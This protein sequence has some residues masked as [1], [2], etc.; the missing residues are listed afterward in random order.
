MLSSA[1]QPY[2]WLIASESIKM[3]KNILPVAWL[4]LSSAPVLVAAA[5]VSE[6]AAVELS[7]CAAAVFL[8]FIC[9]LAEPAAAVDPLPDSQQCRITFYMPVN[10]LYFK[11]IKTRPLGEQIPP[12]RGIWSG[13]LAKFNNDFF[14]IMARLT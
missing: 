12:P 8:N 11:K 7:F 9:G 3:N 13:R 1:L 10:I 2:S 5:E 4:V 14:V 6:S